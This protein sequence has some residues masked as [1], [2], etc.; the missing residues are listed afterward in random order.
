MKSRYGKS[1]KG[2]SN[3]KPKIKKISGIRP[4]PGI[5]PAGTPGNH[6]QGRG[7]PVFPGKTENDKPAVFP[8]SAPFY[9][10][11]ILGNEIYIYRD[12]PL[13]DPVGIGGTGQLDHD[14]R[15]HIRSHR[16]HGGC[17]YSLRYFLE[18]HAGTADD[19]KAFPAESP[20]LPYAGIRNRG[21]PDPCL[22]GVGVYPGKRDLSAADF[23]VYGGSL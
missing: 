3:E 7:D 5:Q 8:K 10:E 17:K 15:S 22:C 6:C 2:Q 1:R 18:G 23:A 20:D 16:V 21:F 14:R 9:R 11:R 19:G 12:L 4:G 13:S